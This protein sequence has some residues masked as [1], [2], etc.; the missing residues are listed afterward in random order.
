M[1]LAL[2]HS[3][4]ASSAGKS[5]R[6]VGVVFDV[7]DARVV[8]A[9]ITFRSKDFEQQVVSGEAGEFEVELPIAKYPYY[10]TVEAHGFC[11]FEGDLLRVHPKTTE[12]INIHLEVQVTHIECKCSSRRK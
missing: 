12:M 10:F 11:K 7:N 1:E 5:G 8:K 4:L 3:S 2:V 6:V 9:T